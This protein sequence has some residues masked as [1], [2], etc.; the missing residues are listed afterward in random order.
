MNNVTGLT[1]QTEMHTVDAQKLASHVIEK[2]AALISDLQTEH[3]RVAK[4]AAALVQAVRLVRDGAIDLDDVEE[5][6]RQ[7][8]AS[9]SVK[10]S[11]VDDVF[12]QTPGDLQGNDSRQSGG[13]E[14]LDPLTK[15]LRSF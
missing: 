1:N 9:G 5:Y 3:H 12:D 4:Y 13:A 7:L 14:K 10:V 6:A 2:Q 15:I 11:A 8:V